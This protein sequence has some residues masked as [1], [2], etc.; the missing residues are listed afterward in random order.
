MID[1]SR[2]NLPSQITDENGIYKLDLPDL[3]DGIVAIQRRGYSNIEIKLNAQEL[4]SDSKIYDLRLRRNKKMDEGIVI[5]SLSSKPVHGAY[6]V[7]IDTADGEYDET[8]TDHEGK[9]N[10]QFIQ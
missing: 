3:I 9:F 8:Y 10:K 5:D 1:L 4:K 2:C 7:A 6:V